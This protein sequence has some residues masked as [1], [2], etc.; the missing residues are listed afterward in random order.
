M[1]KN[2]MSNTLPS[3]AALVSSHNNNLKEDA[4]CIFCNK[5][6]QSLQDCAAIID[7]SLKERQLVIKNKG[8]CFRCL[9][10]RHLSSKCK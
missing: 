1:C 9:K 2:R 7:S 6:T 4:L 3:A 5:L 10:Q 8:V